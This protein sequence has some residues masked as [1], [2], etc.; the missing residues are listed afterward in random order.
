MLTQ[1][2]PWLSRFH[3]ATVVVKF[4]GGHAMIDESLKRAFAQDVVFLR[5]TPADAARR[6]VVHGGGPQ[7]TAQLEPAPASSSGVSPGGLRVTTPGGDG[8]RP[9]GAHRPGPARTGRPDQP[10][11]A[12][13]GVGLSG[14][15][16]STLRWPSSS[17]R[18]LESTAS[19]W[20]SASSATSPRSTRPQVIEALIERRPDPGGLQRGQGR[21]RRRLPRHRRH[22]RR[23]AGGRPGRGEAGRALPRRRGPLRQLGPDPGASAVVRPQSPEASAADLDPIR[24]G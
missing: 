7:I 8:R 9:D 22:R 23:C 15:D 13:R 19:R 20:T 6:L 17:K 5:A 14:E 12:V 18:R 11:R 10:A 1:A 24:L 16:A 21:G 2:L 4:L 3:G